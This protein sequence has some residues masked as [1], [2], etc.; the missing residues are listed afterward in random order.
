M[1]EL[2]ESIDQTEIPETINCMSPDVDPP[3]RSKSEKPKAKL[4]GSDE[5]VNCSWYNLISREEEG[6]FNTEY[7]SYVR[8][9]GRRWE[10]SKIRGVNEVNGLPDKD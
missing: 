6:D 3:K 4:Y 9:C 5:H 2:Q 8:A 1:K 10:N 7:L